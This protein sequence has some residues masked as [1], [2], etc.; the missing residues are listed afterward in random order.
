MIRDFQ[1][2]CSCECTKELVEQVARALATKA[3]R[4]TDFDETESVNGEDWIAIVQNGVNRKVRASVFY[5][6]A[7]GIDAE[8]HTT[9]EWNA[10]TGYIPPAG[11]IIIYSDYKTTTI[12]GESVNVAGIKIGSGNSYVQDLA[13]VGD[14]IRADLN[15]HVNN[16]SIHVSPQ[17]RAKW[18]AKL[19]VNDASEVIDEALVFIRN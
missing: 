3:V 5:A 1:K 13:F 8:V 7:S 18:D 6:A 4:D 9:D 10:M 15:S 12:D 14:D 2:K 17:D 16:S 11:S 19:N